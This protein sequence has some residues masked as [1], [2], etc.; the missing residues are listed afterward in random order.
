RLTDSHMPARTAL[1]MATR[2]GAAVLGRD[3]LGAL[4]AGKA[5]DFIAFDLNRI[6][7]AGALHD[8]VAAILFCAP[9]GVDHS[10][11]HGR[12]VVEDG[13]LVGVD[14]ADLI[15]RHNQLASTLLD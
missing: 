10:F 15:A 1:E 11:V 8:P 7:Y 3:D 5:A 6:E 9:V 2:G 12:R 13:R 4:E 14:L